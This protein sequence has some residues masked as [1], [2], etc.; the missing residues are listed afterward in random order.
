MNLSRGCRDYIKALRYFCRGKDHCWPRQ[1]TIASRLGCS[2]RQVRRY[3]T[4][5]KE[6]GNVLSVKRRPNSSAVYTLQAEMSTPMSTPNVHSVNKVFTEVKKAEEKARPLFIN[7]KNEETRVDL[8]M[9]AFLASGC[10]TMGEWRLLQER[11]PPASETCGE[12]ARAATA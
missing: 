10:S 12:I 8:E 3:Q 9:E 5:A 6:A 4:E 7:W 2:K 1:G 11:I